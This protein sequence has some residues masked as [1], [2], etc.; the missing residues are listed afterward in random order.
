MN[1]LVE[2]TFEIAY[3]A[4]GLIISIIVLLKSKKRIPYLLLAGLGLT[5]VICDAMVIIPKMIGDWCF[6]LNDIYNYVGIGR[7]AIT[8]T[9]TTLFVL[10]YFFYRKIKS[11]EVNPIMDW[12]VSVLAAIRILMTLIPISDIRLAGDYSQYFYRNI[13]FIALSSIVVFYSY[14]WTKNDIDY[15]FEG[16]E[17][18]FIAMLALFAVSHSF[19]TN[20]NVLVISLFPILVGIVA[21]SLIKF[22]FIRKKE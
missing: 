19:K 13:P 21:I 22:R 8:I 9:M 14:K 3:L 2:P 11:K 18:A 1:Q 10:V 7:T 5:L 15:F 20:S 12:F 4:A 16:I 6:K 17:M